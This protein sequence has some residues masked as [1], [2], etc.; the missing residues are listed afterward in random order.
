MRSPI[1]DANAGAATDVAP[2]KK[3]AVRTA[4][5]A[6]V[7]NN[8][9]TQKAAQVNQ[10]A[11]TLASALGNFM[12]GKRKTEMEQRYT[13][14]FHDQGLKTGLSEYQ[15]DLKR[16]GFTEF[17]YGGQ[18][19]EYTGALNASARNASNA[20][21]LEEQEFVESREGMSLTPAQYQKRIQQK[22]TNYNKENFSDAPDAAFAF[23]KNWQDNSNELSRQQYKNNQVYHQQEARRTVAE[24]FQ[25]DLDVYKNTVK[26]NPARAMELGERL[27]ST[28][29]KPLGMS[30][31]AY[32]SVL[33]EEGLTAIEAHDYSSLQLMN[34]S[35]LTKSFNSKERKRYE[36][37]RTIIDSDNFNM[38]EAARLNY[39]TVVGNK[40][41]SVREFQ[42]ARQQYDSALTQI[43]ARDTGT[44]KHL[45]T[46]FGADRWR[47]VIGNQYQAKLEADAAERV[48]DKVD[49]VGLVAQDFEVNMLSAT[50]PAQRRSMVADRLDAIAIARLDP[51]LDEDVRTELNG[52]FITLRKKLDTWTSAL[53]SRKRKDDAT[54][55][56]REQEERELKVGVESLVTGG[57]YV[58][59]TADEQKTHIKGA[60]D[61]VMNQ[62]IPDN[63]ISSINKIEQVFS[64]P[65]TASKAL[66]AAGKFSGYLPDSPEIKTAIRNLTANLHSNL[67]GVEDNVFTE[68]QLNN[69]KSLEVVRQKAPQLYNN[70]FNRDERVANKA[71]MD[72]V[73]LNKGPKETLRLLNQVEQR[74]DT[75]YAGNLKPED[76][77]AMT[78]GNAPRDV[79]DAVYTEYKSHLVL[80]EDAALQAAREF[81]QGYNTKV[82]GT[83]VRFGSTFAPVMGRNLED[84]MK[85]LGKT[86]KTGDVHK[87]GLTRVLGRLV[88]SSK[89]AT[90]S[91]LRRIEQ[92]PNVR[93]SVLEGNLVFEL[94]G[95]TEILSRSELEN[96]INGYSEWRNR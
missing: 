71:I 94:N 74:R 51:T 42:N 3:H 2:S 26:S 83:T 38:A 92:V 64:N 41:S 43:D 49:F 89:D 23:M 96:E 24:G 67:S 25:T 82:A 62:V 35:G 7:G 34:A 11:S 68:D 87:T 50:E 61:S 32:R 70:A 52:E 78:V 20:M 18:S 10:I 58:S 47:G 59:A 13:K 80:G 33:V 81:A 69:A 31:E 44:T 12:E 17:I 57:G 39:L 40:A 65:L 5:V 66:S 63:E 86:Y 53:E 73:R 56:K 15:K 48:A 77:S 60:V 28:E 36:S 85:I 79:Q 16:T 88:G 6:Q 55:L 4:T 90:G 8:K 75:A 19:P 46:T 30:D 45:K 9:S 54:L 27:Y 37:A 76:L 29:N 84:T 72:A 95:R 22:V 91:E 21:M 93:L 1:E 14:A